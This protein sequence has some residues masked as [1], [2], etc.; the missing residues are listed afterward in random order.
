MAK[1]KGR[2]KAAPGRAERRKFL[3]TMGTAVVTAAVSGGTGELTKQLLARP[4][5]VP[6]VIKP[7]P[8][9][10]RLVVPTAQV[11]REATFTAAGRST[12][13]GVGGVVIT[14]GTG[15]LALGLEAAEQPA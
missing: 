7:A 13:F 10:T 15:R 6:I 14:P 1:R 4:V 11:V 5:P 12:V 3:K 2:R 8:V 9:P